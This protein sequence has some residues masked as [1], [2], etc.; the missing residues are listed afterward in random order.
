MGLGV[1]VAVM[2][3]M[4]PAERWAVIEEIGKRSPAGRSDPAPYLEADAHDLGLAILGAWRKGAEL[5]SLA[6]ARMILDA[7]YRK[8]A[9]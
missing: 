7:G 6:L 8:V 9:G 3:H 1:I 2:R 4:T 5:G